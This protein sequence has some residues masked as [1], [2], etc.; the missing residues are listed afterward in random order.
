MSIEYEKYLDDIATM[1]CRYLKGKPEKIIEHLAKF[2]IHH[3]TETEYTEK[4]GKKV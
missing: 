3:L 1:W 4:Y 2:K